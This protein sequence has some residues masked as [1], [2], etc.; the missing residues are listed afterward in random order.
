MSD[1]A[2]VECFEFSMKSRIEFDLVNFKSDAL[3]FFFE[4]EKTE[5][6]ALS[7]SSYSRDVKSK[8]R[9]LTE[10]SMSEDIEI[11]EE[12]DCSRALKI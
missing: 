3:E 8:F 4:T 2:T 6:D 10:F 5:S 7:E 11:K 12:L 1:C 9:A